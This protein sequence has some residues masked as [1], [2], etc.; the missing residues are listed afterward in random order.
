VYKEMKG[1]MDPKDNGIDESRLKSA[2]QLAIRDLV[3]GLPEE[4]VSMAWRSSLN[5]Q[6]LVVA[7][8]QRKKRRILWFSGPAVGISLATA[9]AFVVLFQPSSHPTVKAPEYGIESA[10]LNDHHSS[11]LSNE[12]STAGLNSTEVSTEANESDPVDGL[13][14]EA[15]VES[16]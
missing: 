1:K 6:L 4:T 2:P 7:A 11:T 14:N 9:L 13:W 8:K 15:D 16:L 3:R 5:E 10:I 12:V